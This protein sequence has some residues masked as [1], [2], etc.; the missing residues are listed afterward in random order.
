MVQVLGT[1]A[2]NRWLQVTG[3]GEEDSLEGVGRVDVERAVATQFLKSLDD[4]PE[5]LRR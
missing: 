1:V 5:T 2:R 4:E 3:D